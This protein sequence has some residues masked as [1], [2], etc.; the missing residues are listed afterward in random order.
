M[1]MNV[2]LHSRNSFHVN[3]TTNLLFRLRGM[4][5][6]EGEVFLPGQYHKNNTSVMEAAYM[7]FLLISMH[8]HSGVILLTQ[9]STHFEIRNLLGIKNMRL[10]RCMSCSMNFKQ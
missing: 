8:Y 1:E 10:S 6:S 7:T 5:R 4:Y 2:M 9:R 3:N